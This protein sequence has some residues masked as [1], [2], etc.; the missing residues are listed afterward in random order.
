MI[1]GKIGAFP[2]NLEGQ[3]LL[4]NKCR[5]YGQVIFPKAVFFLTCLNEEMAEIQMSRKGTLYIYTIV[6]MLPDLKKKLLSYIQ[7]LFLYPR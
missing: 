7:A 1:P 3:V 2:E 6:C 5:S 4:A